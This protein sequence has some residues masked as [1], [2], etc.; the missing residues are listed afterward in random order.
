V[1]FDK[2]ERADAHAISKEVI[3]GLS[4]LSMPKNVTVVNRIPEG[5]ELQMHGNILRIVLRNL[6]SNAIKYSHPLEEVELGRT[7]AGGLYVKDT[8]V[9][10]DA[11][12]LATLGKQTVLSEAGTASESGFGL[13]LYVSTELARKSGWAI[14]VDSTVDVG[15]QFSIKPVA[16]NG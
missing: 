11:A 3:D 14:L 13:G 4:H 7:P 10:M 9:G 2:R 16:N 1:H 15:T 5:T 8:G 12:T 6:A